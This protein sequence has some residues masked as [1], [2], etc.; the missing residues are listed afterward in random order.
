MLPTLRYT[1]IAHSPAEHL[2]R[3]VIEIPRIS[4]QK[5]TLEL[6]AWI[7]GSY[8]I[9]DFAQ[10]LHNLKAHTVNS[11]ALVV[12]Q[13]DKQSWQ[14]HTQ[15]EA[16]LVSYEVF[17]FD[18]S[19]R[20]A[21]LFDEYAFFNGTSTFLEVKEL[22]TSPIELCIINQQ[23]AQDWQL[24]C[25]MKVANH[26]PLKDNL[27]LA[28][29]LQ[30]ENA[31]NDTA[32]PDA[33]AFD[34]H[35]FICEDYQELIDHPVLLGQFEKHS[36][37]VSGVTFHFVL[38]GRNETDIKKICDDLV[39]ICQHHMDMFGGFPETEYWFITLLTVDGF[40]GLE[41][42]ASTALMYPRFHLPMKN[43][44]ANSSERSTEYQRFL[45]LCSH[46]L[47]HTW[48]VKR[49]KSEVMINPKL[50]AEAY[51]EQLW[52]YEGFT[53]LF[54]DL[55]LLKTQLVSTDDYLT[56]LG[57]GITRLVRTQGRHKQSVTESSFNAWTKFYKQDANS[58][59]HIVSYYN[60]GAMV[61]LCLDI[62]IRQLSQNKHNLK[63][64]TVL[65]WKEYGAKN[66]GTPNTVVHELCQQHFNIDVSGF[67]DIALYST[68][69]LPLSQL[70]STIGIK[71][72]FRARKH[73]LD[74]G[75]FSNGNADTQTKPA[76]KTTVKHGFGA[77]YKNKETGVS[78]TSV[79]D[80]SP[81][82]RAGLQV[83]DLLISVNN[84]QVNEKN[85]QALID[86]IDTKSTDQPTQE[87]ESQYHCELIVLRQGRVLTTQL[88]IEAAIL[89]TVYLSL[90]DEDLF[91]QWLG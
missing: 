11:Q 62:T 78:I 76:V 69:D 84:W 25:S 89:D 16:C 90:E 52:I 32:A 67:L 60:K 22:P 80:G 4:Q 82:S 55:S 5:I 79:H 73:A 57:Q 81:A 56:L 66:V 26:F 34:T 41:H 51:M 71:L 14:V 38:S 43:Q 54:D 58:H 28:L 50:N 53:S 35:H 68:L 36:F 10:H 17:A 33:I 77:A 29:G 39:P 86:N 48:H 15:G 21:Y 44:M 72:D 88:P 7:P 30:T 13:L 75:G 64:L 37:D 2:F 18:L 42:R 91:R 46:E 47:F 9:R 20:G 45:S 70:L 23:T 85:L 27:A 63:E 12:H 19:V 61:A 31:S 59:N 83:D 24:A 8:M 6:P 40:G 49:T 1:I 74:M 87:C 65:M 3:V